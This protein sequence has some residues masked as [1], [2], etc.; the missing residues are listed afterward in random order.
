MSP[1]LSLR[2]QALKRGLED[3]ELLAALAEHGQNDLTEEL[4]AMIVKGK[5]LT[6]TAASVG[7]LLSLDFQDYA[8]VRRRALEAL[9]SF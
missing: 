7:E 2:Y 4:L 8:L 3:Y 6:E 5:G 9:S 1:L